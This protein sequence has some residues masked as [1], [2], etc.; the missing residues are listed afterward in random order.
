MKYYN[1]PINIYIYIYIYVYVFFACTYVCRSPEFVGY[2]LFAQLIHLILDISRIV[3]LKWVSMI[4]VSGCWWLQLIHVDQQHTWMTPGHQLFW[5]Q[6]L[7]NGTSGLTHCHMKCCSGWWFGT[8]YIFSYIGNNNTN[9]PI[10]FRRGW[11]HHAFPRFSGVDLLRVRSEA[12]DQHLRHWR[13]L[14]QLQCPLKWHIGP[15]LSQGATPSSFGCHE[16]TA[17]QVP[18]KASVQRQ[19]S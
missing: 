10:F 17:C 19:P 2:M 4:S 9:W 3:R 18:E 14:G 12:Y 1:L 6:L 15:V 11:N 13:C 8:F 7:Y 5:F 16:G